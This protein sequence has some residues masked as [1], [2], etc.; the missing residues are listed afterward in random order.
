MSGKA[1]QLEFNVKIHPDELLFAIRSKTPTAF[2]FSKEVRSL[3][4]E[5]TAHSCVRRDC[6]RTWRRDRCRVPRAWR[7]E[8]IRTSSQSGSRH[9]R[10]TRESEPMSISDPTC[11]MCSTV[12]QDGISSRDAD[13]CDFS[14]RVGKRTA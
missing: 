5:R 3:S 12:R 11:H 8:V 10:R 2:V 14:I 6:M 7:V 9:V 13:S 4:Q 1:E